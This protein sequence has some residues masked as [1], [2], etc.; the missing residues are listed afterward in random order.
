M[1]LSSDSVDQPVEGD[2]MTGVPLV[3]AR[4]MPPEPPVVTANGIELAPLA[5]HWI[6]ADEVVR[7]IPADEESI[8]VAQVPVRGP[9]TFTIGHPTVAPTLCVEVFEGL[10]ERLHPTGP[11]RTIL[12]T[13]E[14]GGVPGS[15]IRRRPAGRRG[16]GAGRRAAGGSP[17][18]LHR[19]ARRRGTSRRRAGAAHGLLSDR[20]RSLI[21]AET[22]TFSS[23][24]APPSRR[25]RP[26]ARG[27]DGARAVAPRAA[28]ENDRFWEGRCPAVRSGPEPMFTRDVVSVRPRFRWRVSVAGPAL[29]TTTPVGRVAP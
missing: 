23:G 20:G 14:S 13:P 29:W 27:G 17:G 1:R 19:V 8:E 24:P 16:A 12:C 9:I 28:F 11:G 26:S 5:V 18:G 21:S 4:P 25:G 2:D 6:V 7:S 22:T 10:D 3:E 15:R